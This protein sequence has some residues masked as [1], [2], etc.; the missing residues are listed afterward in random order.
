MASDRPV[1]KMAGSPCR[2]PE[3][4]ICLMPISIF[5]CVLRALPFRARLVVTSSPMAKD[6]R[7]RAPSIFW[8]K[9]D[10]RFSLG[11]PGAKLLIRFIPAVGG[12]PLLKPKS[13][14]SFSDADG[15]GAPVAG[16]VAPKL[17]PHRFSVTLERL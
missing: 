4:R 3:A 5:R 6:L 16:S 9:V 12:I 8:S 11:P 17:Y 14:A 2:S 1:T 7:H 10:I 13:V 15:T